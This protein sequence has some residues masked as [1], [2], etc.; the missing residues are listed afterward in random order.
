LRK[1]VECATSAA[2]AA[3]GT[4]VYRSAEALRHPKPDFFRNLFSRRPRQVK[5][6]EHECS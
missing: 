6:K 2:K 3:E 4:K 5:F 1:K